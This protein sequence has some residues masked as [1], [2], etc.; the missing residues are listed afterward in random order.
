M[1]LPI[2][3][4]EVTGASLS[5]DLHPVI[6]RI[7]R[8]RN[9]ANLDD[10]ENGLKGL[11]HFNVLKGMPQ[12]AQILA[13]AVVQNKRIIIVG[14]FDA[15]GAT[16]TS[17]CILAL[18]AMGY[19]NVDFLVPNRFDFG[20]GLSVPIVDEAAKQ[21]AEVIVTVDNGISCI[22]GVTHAKS[23]GMQVVV[24]DHHLPGDVLPPADAIVNPNQ[25]GCEFPSKNL[26]GVGVA[27]YIMLALKAELQQQGHF[28]RAGLAPPN[29]AS[30]LDIVAVGTV[31]DVVVLD[32]NNRI[33]VHQGLQRIRAGK[34]RPGIKALVEVANRDCAHLTSTDLGFVVG[35][36]LNA[37]GRLDDMSQGIACL[38]E[39]ETI[40]ARMI[41]AEL[42]ALNK[43]RREI[44][45]GMKA[46]AEIVLEQMALDEGDM[47]SALVVYREDFHQG[48]IGIVA[49]RLKEKYLKPVIAF[50]HQDDEIIKGSARSIPGVHIRDVLDEVNTRYPGVIEKF[51]GHAMA[52][53]LSLPVA[54]LQDFEQAFVDIARAHMAKLDGNHALLSD[55]DLSSKEL[56]LPF[57]H[58][59][60]QAGPFGQGF[61]SPL[62]DG[63]FALLDQ[64]LVGQKHL[65]MVL[66]SDGANEVDA[67]AFNVDLKS[68][69]NAM[70][71]RVHIAYR[72]DINVFRGQETVQLIVEQI[73]AR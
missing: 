69:P 59:L 41:A 21:R 47:P 50:A 46:Q 65:K 39:D 12:A 36:R 60:R 2:V 53:G 48:V 68:W 58:L 5:S 49:G 73:E 8:G 42:D 17:V 45:T 29:L 10:L 23:L 61:E 18:R 51:G 7:Y 66:K 33:L 38:L 22:D 63:E 9:I 57:A 20:Y 6:D 25:P 44:E 1:I 15:D 40:Q 62:F 34:C 31:A 26:A 14:D 13:N 54:K 67:I 71:K 4:R 35:P 32:K 55:G 30:L 28:E 37:A 56:C 3:R 72:L 43:E 52:A 70:V 19:Q 16:S 11:T 27:F 64:R 24:T